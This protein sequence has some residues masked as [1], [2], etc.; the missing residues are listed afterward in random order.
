MLVISYQSFKV[1]HLMLP[2]F[3]L[4]DYLD[5]FTE[6]IAVIAVKNLLQT[7]SLKFS[8]SSPGSSP[9]FLPNSCHLPGNYFTS[10]SPLN[11]LTVLIHLH[12]PSF[13]SHDS[14]CPS[15]VLIPQAFYLLQVL[16]LTVMSSLTRFFNLS[17]PTAFSSA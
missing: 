12:L 11:W 4:A 5:Y 14:S 16:A 2:Y 10:S 3:P 6:E 9:P 13:H 15:P 1:L 17:L 7:I 8:Y